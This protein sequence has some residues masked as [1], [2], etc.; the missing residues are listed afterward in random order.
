MDSNTPKKIN[1]DHCK[2]FCCRIS[3]L[4]TPSNALRSGHLTEVNHEWSRQSSFCPVPGVDIVL[5]QYDRGS[6]VGKNQVSIFADRVEQLALVDGQ[7]GGVLREVW[8]RR[9]VELRRGIVS[10]SSSD[11]GRG[12]ELRW[13]GRAGCG[14]KCP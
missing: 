4:T 5:V 2:V 9:R 6:D 3:S 14:V 7:R 1:S 11:V 13:L 12:G 10:H 8:P